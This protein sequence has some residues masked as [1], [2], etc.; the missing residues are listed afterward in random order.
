MG[1][2]QR[3][4]H[5]DGLVLLAVLITLKHFLPWFAGRHVL[6]WLDDASVERHIHLQGGT[7]SLSSLGP[8]QWLL[9][10]AYRHLLSLRATYLPG[11]Q[12]SVAGLLSRSQPHPGEWRLHP[13]VVR[14]VWYMYGTAEVWTFSPP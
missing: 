1:P 4:Q 8:T 7:R 6:V 9:S 12:D 3:Q 11:M 2:T 10:W 5:M 13:D 14:A